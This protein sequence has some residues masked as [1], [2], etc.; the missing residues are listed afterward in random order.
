MAIAKLKSD[1]VILESKT[2]D[3]TGTE[4][5]LYYNSTNKVFKYYNDTEWK[6]L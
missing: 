2:S 4:G 1:S 5:Q 3:P 6:S